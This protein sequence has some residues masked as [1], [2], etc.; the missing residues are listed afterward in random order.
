MSGKKPFEE[1]TKTEAR[2]IGE[3]LYADTP[4]AYTAG[5]ALI[6]VVDSVTVTLGRF[7]EGTF[8]ITAEGKQVAIAKGLLP[9]EP[10]TKPV[11]PAQPSQPI[12][13]PP[14][15]PPEISQLPAGPGDAYPPLKPGQLP[16]GEQ[17]G[18]DQGL[19]GEPPEASQ[20]PV[21]PDV[22]PEPLPID[23]DDPDAPVISQ[24]P[25]GPGDQFP[26]PGAPGSELPKPPEGET[27]PGEPEVPPTAATLPDMD[28]GE[29]PTHPIAP[30]FPSP[31]G[32]TP[33][34]P[35]VPGEGGEQPAGPSTQPVPPP[36]GSTKPGKPAKPSTQPVPPQP[37][38][39]Q[40][41]PPEGETE[42]ERKRRLELDVDVD[43]VEQ[44]A[45]PPAPK[46]GKGHG[47]TEGKHHRLDLS[48]DVSTADRAKSE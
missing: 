5:G 32:G 16:T 22:S 27:K 29:G 37:S 35:M 42:E 28:F 23:P 45:P 20:V 21:Q 9:E 48:D 30:S 47:R 46:S 38:P 40:G 6:A 18:P 14:E 8:I 2:E 36:R 31:G 24:L 7:D 17:P 3:K 44:P 1:L 12:A 26:P 10:E 19:P 33:T 25:A 13:E 11:E 43:R 34:Q 15:E 41:L 4:G 39:D